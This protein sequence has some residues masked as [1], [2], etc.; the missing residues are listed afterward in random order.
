MRIFLTG[1]TGYVG[2]AVLDALVRGWTRRHRA[3]ARQRESAPRRRSAARIRSSAISPIPSRTGPPPTRRTATFTPPR[4]ASADGAGDRS[5]ALETM[6]GAARR[7]R[8]AGDAPAAPR[9]VIYTSGVWVLGRAPEPADEDAPINPVALA[10]WRPAHEQL[11]LGGGERAPADR[12]GPAGRRL[13]RRQRHGRRPLQV[14]EQRPGARGRRR[15][16]PLAAR[17]RPRPR[18]SLRAAR[19]AATMPRASITPTTK[20]TSA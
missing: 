10:A 3:R 11:V 5:P 9:F 13:R 17:L 1:A 16:Q 4:S 18:G 15:Q 20:A 14:G 7:P 2:A 6:L 8:T 12:R 19:R